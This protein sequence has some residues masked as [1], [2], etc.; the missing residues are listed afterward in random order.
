MRH[1]N[2]YS[3]Y[4]SHAAPSQLQITGRYVLASVLIWFALGLG[5]FVFLFSLDLGGGF[6]LAFLGNGRVARYLFGGIS[7]FALMTLACGALAAVPALL[8]QFSLQPRIDQITRKSGGTRTFRTTIFKALPLAVFGFTQMVCVSL[9]L[10]AAPQLGRSWTKAPNLVSEWSLFVYGLFFYPLENQTV[11]ERW[12]EAFAK[13]DVSGGRG[14]QLKGSRPQSLVVLL[15]SSLLSHAGSLPKVKQALGAPTPFVLTMPSVPGLVEQLHFGNDGLSER[16]LHP[17]ASPARAHGRLEKA[18]APLPGRFSL[19]AEYAALEGGLASR[20]ASSGHARETTGARMSK[21]SKPGGGER[22]RDFVALRLAQSQFQLFPLFR[23]G[24]LGAIHPRWKPQF[25]FND[26]ARQIEAFLAD[27]EDVSFERGGVH[28]LLL[29]ET[30]DVGSGVREP[31]SPLRWPADLSSAERKWLQAKLD[32]ALA[33]GINALQAPG[34]SPIPIPIAIVPYPDRVNPAALSFAY[35]RGQGPEKAALGFGASP[36]RWAT[37]SDVHTMLERV[38]RSGGVTPEER[39]VSERVAASPVA[40][41]ESEGVRCEMARLDFD[42][43]IEGRHDRARGVRGAV[44]SAIARASEGASHFVFPDALAF[45][46]GSHLETTAVCQTVGAA[47]PV[48]AA[49]RPGADVLPREELILVRER[50]NLDAEANRAASAGNGEEQTLLQAFMRFLSEEQE[51]ARA[52]AREKARALGNARAHARGRGAEAKVP[53]IDPA[54]QAF[55]VY[56]VTADEAQ[57]FSIEA[58]EGQARAELLGRWKAPL[59]SVFARWARRNL[60]GAAGTGTGA[61][62]GANH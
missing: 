25:I 49:A 32:T 27:A 23:L 24:L 18:M 2:S 14:A 13:P 59:E 3:K 37:A 56:R 44:W 4:A 11:A 8:V 16:F 21:G 60:E 6:D 45:L 50:V 38:F 20:A 19:G 5:G 54:L 62:D 15:P 47:D 46:P 26:D 28:Y 9:S 22:F 39:D 42:D 55:E 53:E 48:W 52:K 12:R 34:V 36:A 31:S 10:G 40:G 57:K 7:A 33:V 43:L 17:L 29:T 35:V 58:V 41:V 51:V 30:E 1:R 61:R